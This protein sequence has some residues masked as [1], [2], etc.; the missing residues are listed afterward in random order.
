VTVSILAFA[1]LLAAAN[2]SNDDPKGVATLGGTGV[3]SYRRALIWGVVATF[4]GAMLSLHLAAALTKLFSTGVITAR[5]T[6]AF[7]LSVLVGAT[8][9][10]TFATIRR[11]PVS[12]THALVGA[13]IG[14]G[15]VL[16]PHTVAWAGLVPKVLEPLLLSVAVAI[17]HPSRSTRCPAGS[18]N[19][20]ACDSRN[21]RPPSRRPRRPLSCTP[22]PHPA[23][24]FRSYRPAP[25]PNARHTTQPGAAPR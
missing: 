9:W 10:V 14:V 20:S 13:L 11:L 19:A 3:A 18:P 17:W 1:V 15:L 2:G 6:P 25:S 22:R 5:P 12:T 24:P 16:G 4:A 8:A 23:L 21:S 7:A